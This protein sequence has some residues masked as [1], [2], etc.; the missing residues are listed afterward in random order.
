MTLDAVLRERPVPLAEVLA[1][2]PG[3]VI[4]LDITAHE[5][6]TVFCAG[7]PMLRAAMGRRKNSSVALRVTEKLIPDEEM[8]NAAGD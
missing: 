7:R 2:K 6:V 5:E 4:D 3:A 1:W 8:R